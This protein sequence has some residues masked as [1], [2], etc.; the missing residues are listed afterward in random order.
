MTTGKIFHIVIL[1]LLVSAFFSCAGLQEKP[2]A[3]S[4]FEAGMALFQKGKYSDAIPH[5]ITATELDQEFG[6]PYLYLGRSYLNLGKWREALPP[7]RTALRIVPEETK[8]EVADILLDII[9]QNASKFDRDTH[10]E[11]LNLLKE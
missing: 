5:F 11:I 3:E 1:I 10:S 9:L 6:K 7:L 2:T 4:E 8:K